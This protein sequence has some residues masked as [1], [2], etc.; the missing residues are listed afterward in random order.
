[1]PS[2]NNHHRKN[3]NDQRNNS[4]ADDYRKRFKEKM[5]RPVYP[6]HQLHHIFPKGSL[7]PAF[8]ALGID[9]HAP[10]NLAELPVIELDNGK[11]A[12]IHQEFLHGSD[13]TRND[14]E[15]AFLN[16]F[17]IKKGLAKVSNGIID[18]QRL[19]DLSE[20]EKQRYRDEAREFA[21][22][23]IKEATAGIDI[24]N[25]FNCADCIG[26]APY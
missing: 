17:F 19:K 9:I 21:V 25:G 5:N 1:V 12:Y 4:L 23:F 18:F 14:T 20:T 7:G 26:G 15:V 3:D 22:N 10:E 13:D 2:C 6:G 24:G 8:M 16:D 11:K